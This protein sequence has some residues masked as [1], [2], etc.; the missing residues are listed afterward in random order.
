MALS[1]IQAPTSPVTVEEFIAHLRLEPLGAEPTPEE[2]AQ[3][4]LL[5][6]YLNA[7]VQH[8]RNVT[9]AEPGVNG[10]YLLSTV[11]DGSGKVTLPKPPLLSIEEV[12]VDG[13]VLD[14]SRYTILEGQPGEVVIDAPAGAKVAISFTA[15]YAEADEVPDTL[16]VAILCIAAHLFENREATNVVELK[17][18]PYVQ[19]MLDQYTFYSLEGV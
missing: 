18:N 7:A 13:Q 6:R 11:L 8:V 15:G 3:A 1:I 19:N 12:K 16:K 9:H 14:S 10:K 2:A 4:S 17:A 5:L